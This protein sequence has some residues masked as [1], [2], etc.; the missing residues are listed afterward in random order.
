[1]AK[2]KAAKE[3]ARGGKP[4]TDERADPFTGEAMA[5]TE[6]GQLFIDDDTPSEVKAMVDRLKKATKAKTKA[7]KDWETARD[8]AIG[9]MLK[10]DVKAIIF[11]Q[12]GRRYFLD[13][14]YSI[15]SE[16]MKGE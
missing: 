2:K 3:R 5:D 15:K 9:A 7:T 10:A 6:D 12:D 13:T 14:T 8:N 1:M 11:K 4:K 16:P